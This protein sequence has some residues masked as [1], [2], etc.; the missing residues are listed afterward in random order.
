LRVLISL[1]RVLGDPFL[2]R[3][4]NLTRYVADDPIRNVVD[5]S[6]RY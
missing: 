6:D 1:F 4:P 3:Q 2:L 5:L